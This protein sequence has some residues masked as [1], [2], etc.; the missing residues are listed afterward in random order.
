MTAA[1]LKMKAREEL[2]RGYESSPVSKFS[3]LNTKQQSIEAVRFYIARI[4]NPLKT[5]ISDED[6]DGG[7]VDGS[8]DLGCDFIHRDDNHVLIIQAKYRKNGTAERPEDISHFKSIL[9]RF[10]QGDLKLNKNLVAIANEI[11]WA[12]DTFELVYMTFGRMDRESQARKLASDSAVYPAKV[13]DLEDRCEWIFLDEEDLNIQLRNASGLQKGVAETKIDLTPEGSRGQRGE[14]SIIQSGSGGYK[15]YV[16]VLSARQLVEAYVKLGRDR[17]FS[18]NIRNYIGNTH[19]NKKIIE[20]AIGEPEQFFIFNNGISCLATKVEVLQQCISV[21]GLQVINGAQTVK[22]LVHVSGNISRLGAAHWARHTPNILV[23]ITEISEGYGTAGRVRERITQYNNTQNIIKISDFRSND[24]VQVSLKKQ[25]EELYRKGKKVIYLAKRTD[26]VPR[27]SEVVRIEEFAKTVYAFLYD[28]VEF[29]GSS[30]FLFNDE[31]D[32]GYV[33]VFGDGDSVWESVPSDQFQLRAAIYWVAQEIASRLK[34]TRGSE[35]DADARA[36]LERKWCVVYAFSAAIQRAFPNGEWK[37]Q[38]RRLYR[39]DWTM[40]EGKQGEA[41]LELYEIAKS[42]V[43]FAY[44]A[45]KQN[46]PEEFVHRSW[47][48]SK[49]TPSEISNALNLSMA[50]RKIGQIPAQ[51]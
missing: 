15:S 37:N 51:N 50:G 1:P 33:K 24:L 26:V 44:T 5:F 3:A 16:M 36:A 18:L 35:Q 40:G 46:N 48:R 7:V 42:A 39:G 2:I 27:N 8:D 23:R 38:L 25:F 19:T 41:V 12:R 31:F 28:F 30:S 21:T 17:I 49:K 13:R 34:K 32:G 4:H 6:V 9:K 11:D 14:A 10:R 29:S 20:T 22:A 47:M 45:A 43:V